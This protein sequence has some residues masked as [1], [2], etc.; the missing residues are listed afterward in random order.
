[1]AIERALLE[2]LRSRAD[3]VIDTT[4]MSAAMLA[5]KSRTSSSRARRRAAWR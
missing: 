1:V 2:P 3:L 4:G 5:G